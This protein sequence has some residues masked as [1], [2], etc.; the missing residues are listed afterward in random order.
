MN[1]IDKIKII[2]KYTKENC[3][4]ICYICNLDLKIEESKKMLLSG[5][6]VTKI[7]E[8][9]NFDSPNYFTKVFR[10]KVGCSPTNY[11]KNQ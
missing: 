3:M 6:R 2:D 4:S 5:I 1:F 11:K 8:K 9:L 7:S 10:K